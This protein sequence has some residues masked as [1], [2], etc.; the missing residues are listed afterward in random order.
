MASPKAILLAIIFYY[1]LLHPKKPKKSSS[2]NFLLAIL[3]IF[4]IFTLFTT[5]LADHSDTKVTNTTVVYDWETPDQ[6]LTVIWDIDNAE[7]VNVYGDSGVV[8]QPMGMIIFPSVVVAGVFS[9]L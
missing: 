9:L 3:S 8:V 6:N 1:M 5:C 7:T 4:T 2:N